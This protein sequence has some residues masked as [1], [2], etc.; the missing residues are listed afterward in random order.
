MWYNFFP[1]GPYEEITYG[2]IK[3]HKTTFNPEWFGVIY[4]KIL[5]PTNILI[6]VLQTRIKT[7]RKIDIGEDGYTIASTLCRTCAEFKIN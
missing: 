7:N 2:Q 1:V 5:P 6:T 4:C 3:F